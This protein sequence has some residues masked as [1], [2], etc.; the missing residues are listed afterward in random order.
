MIRE[1]ES[2]FWESIAA[3]LYCGDGYWLI[4]CL[5]VPNNMKLPQLNKSLAIVNS[6]QIPA[7]SSIRFTSCL[8]H[9]FSCTHLHPLFLCVTLSLAFCLPR[10]A[11]HITVLLW[12]NPV[13]G[14]LTRS[15]FDLSSLPLRVYRLFV[16]LRACCVNMFVYC[17]LFLTAM[18][19]LSSSVREDNLKY[20][21]WP[22][23]I[24]WPAI[25]DGYH[26]VIDN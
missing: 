21:T 8:L 24:V 18:N 6:S 17:Y 5:F 15:L 11:S 16:C 7:L 3:N 14:G 25:A 12:D 10:S 19:C 23:V 20:I 4:E 22:T 26:V 1:R 2:E 9:F 13:D